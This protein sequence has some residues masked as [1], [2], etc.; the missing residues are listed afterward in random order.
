[1]AVGIDVIKSEK[2][3]SVTILVPTAAGNIRIL[4][5]TLYSRSLGAHLWQEE[6]L[7]KFLFR[8]RGFTEHIF[9]L[10]Q[11]SAT[12]LQ[13]SPFL[14]V[15]SR[16]TFYF[17][18]FKSLPVTPPRELSPGPLRARYLDRDISPG[19]RTYSTFSGSSGREEYIASRGQGYGTYHP[20]M[21]DDFARS[22]SGRKEYPRQQ[23]LAGGRE[24]SHETES[25]E[26][27]Q[28]AEQREEYPPQHT[29]PAYQPHR[30][31]EHWERRSS[32]MEPAIAAPSFRVCI[33]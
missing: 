13:K 19:E 14:I 8:I 28:R 26:D 16:I 27:F 20:G 25:R 4:T 30:A 15:K 5:Q 12:I 18:M 24:E 17:L 2:K 31:P 3:Y 11:E 29:R 22:Q 1:M 23:N 6:K 33:Q 21:R 9:Y 10:L 32:A 7:I